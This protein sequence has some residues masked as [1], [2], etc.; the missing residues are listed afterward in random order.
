MLLDAA[1]LKLRDRFTP[2]QKLRLAENVEASLD[3]SFRNTNK[4]SQAIARTNHVKSDRLISSERGASLDEARPPP[5]SLKR[6]AEK[7]PPSRCFKCCQTELEARRPMELTVK[8]PEKARCPEKMSS[9]WPTQ[10]SPIGAATSVTPTYT[11][12][13]SAHFY[14]QFNQSLQP[15]KLSLWVSAEHL[16]TDHLSLDQSTPFH[17]SAK[18]AHS[19]LT[20]RFL[21]KQSKV[22]DIRMPVANNRRNSVEE[23]MRE[24]PSLSLDSS[25]TS[26]FAIRPTVAAAQFLSSV[27][28]VPVS[29][30]RHSVALPSSESGS[31]QSAEAYLEPNPKAHGCDQNPLTVEQLTSRD[32]TRLRSPNSH[33]AMVA[34]LR[35]AKS[36][37]VK[38]VAL[39]PSGRLKL[40]AGFYV[41]V[42]PQSGDVVVGKGKQKKVF[43]L[44]TLREMDGA[45]GCLARVQALWEDFDDVSAQTKGSANVCAYFEG[46]SLP[47]MLVFEAVEDKYDFLELVALNAKLLLAQ[48]DLSQIR[49]NL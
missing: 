21:P 41:T 39:L 8:H 27:E 46:R 18:P 49:I 31:Y 23:Y 47:C 6:P 40:L 13:E 33:R 22:T 5:V 36:V 42:E 35:F 10:A 30:P 26:N 9:E 44:R 16:P 14:S 28:S 2:I 1:N 38:L 11:R 17:E 4:W 48:S 3:G 15:P 12:Q 25:T 34:R 20:A 32:G 43:S 29:V 45:D 24:M 37:P 19:G 7:H